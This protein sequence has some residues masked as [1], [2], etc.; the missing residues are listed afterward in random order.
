MQKKQYIIMQN[1]LAG[2][3]GSLE[4]PKE[5][6]GTAVAS[7]PPPYPDLFASVTGSPESGALDMDGVR[8]ELIQFGGCSAIL[9]LRMAPEELQAELEELRTQNREL[10]VV[11]ESSIDGFT[12]ADGEGKIMRV[13]SS[14]AQIAGEPVERF[15]GKTVYELADEGIFSPSATQMALERKKPTTVNQLFRNGTK[16]T[17]NSSNPVFNEDGTLYRVVTNVRDMSEV[18]SLRTELEES[19]VLIDHYAHL[20][21]K[22]TRQQTVEGYHSS[23]NSSM[24]SLYLRAL[25]YASVTAPV[26]IIGESGT[27]KELVADFIHSNSPR[28]NKPFLKINCGAVPEQLLEAEL[29]GYEGGAFTGARKQGRTGLFE[30]ANGGTVFLDEVGEMPLAVQV[31]LLR[32]VQNREFYRLGGSRLYTVD[33]RLIAATNRDLEAMVTER[34]FR[35]DLFYRL[36]VLSLFVPPLRDRVEDIVPLANHFLQKF[37]EQYAHEKYL[38]PA[39]CDLFESYPWPGNV[40]EMAN[41]LERLAIIRTGDTITQAHLP[42]QMRKETGAMQPREYGGYRE[43]AEAFEK[44]YWSTVLKRYK[45]Y[46]QA[47]EDLGVNHSTIVKKVAR[48]KIESPMG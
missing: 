34:T 31:K 47:A 40:R 15:V 22:M 3:D 12:I 28:K 38:S 5:L 21:E 2:L 4:H 16:Q 27:G 20:L 10:E 39:V 17:L 43:T 37:N 7:L 30:V 25:E 41:L 33:V 13:N 44:E 35:A 46:R 19:K 26:L 6:A 14:Y 29:F 48:Y 45:S 1:C 23:N 32:F 42:E 11:M 18:H 36:N 9:F 24:Q 8:A